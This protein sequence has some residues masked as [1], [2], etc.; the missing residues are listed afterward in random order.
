MNIGVDNDE[1]REPQ[2]EAQTR[3]NRSATLNHFFY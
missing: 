2:L 3:E 1:M